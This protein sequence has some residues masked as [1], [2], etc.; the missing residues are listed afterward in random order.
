MD[1]EA[2]I[3]YAERGWLVVPV[4]EPTE[5]G[6]SCHRGADCAAAGKHP[7][8][9][10]WQNRC[11]HFESTVNGWLDDWP[12][13]NVGIK[14][15]RESDIIDIE[16][17]S[18]EIEAALVDL[19]GGKPP[20]TPMFAASRG[21]HRL[22]RWTPE[23]PNTDKAVF[24]HRGIE[25]RLGG[26]GMG[27]QSIFPPSVHKS[28]AVY[29][30]IVH[31]DECEIQELSPEFV[32]RLRADMERT[33]APGGK[34]KPFKEFVS[35]ASGV[36]EGGR[37]VGATRLIGKLL[38]SLG[39]VGTAAGDITD[40]GYP[41][42]VQVAVTLIKAWNLQNKP[43]LDEEELFDAFVSILS[44][45]RGRRRKEGPKNEENNSDEENFF[46]R[47]D[48]HETMEKLGWKLVAERGEPAMFRIF[49]PLWVD[50]APEGY[51]T[52]KSA[53][54][55][56]PQSIQ[57][58]AISQAKKVLPKL[59][60]SWWSGDSKKGSEWGG[61]LQVLLDADNEVAADQETNPYGIALQWLHDMAIAAPSGDPNNPDDAVL[62]IIKHN[63]TVRFSFQQASSD[64]RSVDKEI[65]QSVLRRVLE[66]LG[67]REER[68]C[69]RRWR[70]LGPAALDLLAD[71]C[72]FNSEHP[73]LPSLPIE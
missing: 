51:I 45:E 32:A 8:I 56:S 13:M 64:L 72:G 58:A 43:P 12:D 68:I 29:K 33:G 7:R 52:V 28:G 10:E 49:S 19:F 67:A 42:P 53:Q 15:G 61:A 69:N 24:F 35:L 34:K 18:E 36:Q 59:F 50:S 38:R 46:P 26:G 11:S 20:E 48:D 6:C 27:A 62:P 31:P 37:K 1:R 23:M 47:V 57:N 73:I 71:R 2:V 30:W 63:G 5:T 4:H 25:F 70:S 55:L 3:D 22:F 44:A 14:L 16:C 60:K 39:N 17:D 21:N 40:G 65:T 9:P 41:E 66:D 54:I